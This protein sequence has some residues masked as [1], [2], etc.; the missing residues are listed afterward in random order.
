MEKISSAMAKKGYDTEE[1][2]AKFFIKHDHDF[3]DMLDKQS[4]L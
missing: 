1:S 4:F 2:I 3:D